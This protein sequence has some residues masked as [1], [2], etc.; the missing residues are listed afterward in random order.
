[1][2]EAPLHG[3][4]ALCKRRPRRASPTQQNNGPILGTA[5]KARPLQRGTPKSAIGSRA[6]DQSCVPLRKFRPPFLDLEANFRFDYRCNRDGWQV[7]FFGAF[8]GI[9]V[10]LAFALPVA[11]RACRVV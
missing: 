9:A 8:S 5:A 11:E 7:G 4:R 6:G 2:G 3:T 1:M 10:R